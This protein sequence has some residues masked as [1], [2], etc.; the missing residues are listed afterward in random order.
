MKCSYTWKIASGKLL[1]NSSHSRQKKKETK[2][3]VFWHD[4]FY[5]QTVSINIICLEDKNV[6]QT[7]QD[8]KETKNS[9]ALKVVLSQPNKLVLLL[10]HLTESSEVR[11]EWTALE[12]LCF[13]TTATF[14]CTLRVIAETTW[15]IELRRHKAEM[16]LLKRN[17]FAL[18]RQA[19]RLRGPPLR[20]AVKWWLARRCAEHMDA[21]ERGRQKG[22][23][24]EGSLLIVRQLALQLSCV[25]FSCSSFFSLLNITSPWLKVIEAAAFSPQCTGF[26][27]GVVTPD[28][29]RE[30]S[31]NND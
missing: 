12:V 28:Y 25:R 20:Q 22:E 13:Q 26:V 14:E 1:M 3:T 8:H 10:K 29:R 19:D 24:Q 23:H 16:L 2:T 6:A 18:L 31:H 30:T 9:F 7:C 5:P 21:G 4:L 15:N 27:W 17:I 11:E